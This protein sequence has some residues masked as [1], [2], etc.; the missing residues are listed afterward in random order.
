M[1][2]VKCEGTTSGLKLLRKAVRRRAIVLYWMEATA[3][4]RYAAPDVQM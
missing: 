2:G 4:T 3:R 1:R